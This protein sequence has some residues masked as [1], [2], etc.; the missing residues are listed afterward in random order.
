MYLLRAFLCR[1]CAQPRHGIADTAPR[2]QQ[3]AVARTVLQAD[4]IKAVIERPNVGRMRRRTQRRVVDA[5]PRSCTCC[6]SGAVH[7]R[8]LDSVGVAAA[9]LE[10]A[11]RDR[12]LDEH[13][14]RLD[15]ERLQEE[16]VVQCHRADCSTHH[17]EVARAWENDAV[18]HD[19]V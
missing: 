7:R 16:H 10:A 9:H 15:G 8:R 13:A 19:M 1:A 3:R 6:R 4:R 18:L 17:L 14:G 11:V 2:L 12:A 5:L